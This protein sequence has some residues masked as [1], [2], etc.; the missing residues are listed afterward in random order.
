M[1]TIAKVIIIAAALGF[2]LGVAAM[3]LG[4]LIGR[5]MY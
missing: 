5:G 1:N 2:A 4:D 3:S